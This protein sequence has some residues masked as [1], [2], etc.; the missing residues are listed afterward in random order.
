MRIVL[1][2]LNENSFLSVSLEVRFT[3]MDGTGY[4]VMEIKPLK[5]LYSLS[6]IIRKLLFVYTT[7]VAT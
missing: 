3:T 4:Y 7:S 6:N 2:K 5:S 1:P